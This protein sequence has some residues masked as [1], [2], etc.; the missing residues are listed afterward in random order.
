MYSPLRLRCL[1]VAP[2]SQTISI[3]LYIDILHPSGIYTGGLALEIR[4][5]VKQSS[6]LTLYNAANPLACFKVQ[7]A[8]LIIKA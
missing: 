8:I 5:Q 1:Y 6:T 7:D 4:S 3:Y 2:S